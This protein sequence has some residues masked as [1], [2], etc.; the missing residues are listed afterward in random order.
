MS[1]QGKKKSKFLVGAGVGALLV[2]MAMYWRCSGRGS[3]GI[4]SPQRAVSTSSSDT[5][6]TKQDTPPAP[7]CELRMDSAGLKLD[8]NPVELSVAVAACKKAGKANLFITGGANH[9]KLQNTLAALQQAKV[10][11]TE[12]RKRPGPEQPKGGDESA[13]PKPDGDKPAAP[14]PDGDKPAAPKPA[15]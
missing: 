10:Q 8:G 15:P 1:K 3:F 7:P 5:K 4:G 13:A 12:K 9:G 2:V 11:V 14:K 6:T